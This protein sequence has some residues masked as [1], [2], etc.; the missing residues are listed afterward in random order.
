MT[1]PEWPAKEVHISDTGAFLQAEFKDGT[2]RQYT[3]ID[4]LIE[5]LHELG[6]H[7]DQISTVDWHEDVDRA[8]SSGAKISLFHG[9]RKKYGLR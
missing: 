5:H 6:I 9:L 8:P 1:E 3:H 4:E 7:P 2:V